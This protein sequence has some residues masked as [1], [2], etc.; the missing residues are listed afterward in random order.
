MQ[1]HRALPLSGVLVVAAGLAQ[2]QEQQAEQQGEQIEEIVVTGSYIPRVSQFDAPAPLTTIGRED[3]AAL[4]VNEISEV[5]DDLTINTGSQNNPDAFTQN[6]ST[7]T[8]N[9]NL[10]GLGVSSTLVM[11]NGRR[12]VQSA[13]ATDRGENFVDTSSL[14]PMIVFDRIEILKDGATSLYGSEAV[15][16]VVN[17]LTRMDF[18]GI[19]LEVGLQTVDGHPQEDT[20]VSVLWGGGSENT[21]VLAAVSMLDR[22]PLTTNDRRLSQPADDTSQ[23]GNPGSFLVP[24]LPANPAYALVWTAAFDTN[25]NGVADALEPRLGLPPVPGARLPV[26]ADPD[27]VTIAAQDPNVVPAIAA[28]VPTPIGPIPLGLCQ[29]DFGRFYSLVPEE[30]RASAYLEVSHDFSE[31]FRGRLELHTADNEATRNNSPSFPFAQF[32][33]VPASHPDNPYGTNVS[34]IGRVAGAGGM[35]SPSIH[36]SDTTRIAASLAGD[37][38]GRWGWDIGVTNSTNDF[39]VF[40]KDVLIDRFG[41]A[42]QGLGG[43]ACDPTTGTPGAG[44]CA[45]FNP[46]GSSL[47]GTGTQNSAALFEDI[48]GDFSYDAESELTTLDG[49]VTGLLGEIGGGPIGIAAGAQLRQEDIAYDY[50]PNSNS[51][52]FFF[53]A[54]NPDFTGD[55]DV[56]AVFGEVVL[57]VTDELEVQL[58]ARYEDYGGGVDSADPKIN[59]LW[60]PTLDLSVRASAGTSFRAPSL[61][62]QFGVQTTLAELIDP[63]VG[64]P[65]FFPVRAQPNPNGAPLNPEEADVLTLGVSYALTENIELGADY[66][67]FDYSE[68]IIQ[69]DPQAILN[70]A[71]LG[72]PQAQTQ[73][74]RD[75]ASGLLLRVDSYYTN[76]STLDTDG[77]DLS[78]TYSPELDRGGSL[79]LGADM[80]L[81]KSYDIVDPQAGSVDGLG[82][83]N[84]ANFATSTPELRANLFANWAFGNHGINVYVRHIDSY[85]DDQVDLGQG[86]SS[87][88]PIDSHVTLDA[89]YN[90]AFRDGAG[91]TLT[92]GATNLLDE[93]P[94]YLATNGGYDSKV[95]DPRGRV[96]YAKASFT[97]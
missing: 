45:Y 35:A 33:T 37:I 1:N 60:R 17:F 92:F 83:R 67:S 90:I 66:W 96:L 55:R 5:I 74:I 52:N 26:F 29:F 64:I 58:A 13:V 19:D 38:G 14:P 23:A 86:P 82:R 85:L 7:G 75:P 51:G 80:T 2:A 20:Q 31:R 43:P 76:A 42:I 32:P 18:R 53:F 93:D 62:Q 72:D 88:R 89:Q 84:F 78:I 27:C 34:F 94:P 50:D 81:I 22:K 87:Y 77:F 95:H 4:G 12:Q 28:S 47:T 97:F 73:V 91:P 39:A 41:L 8:S 71:A 46:W 48:F 10:R 69:Q 59:L 57:P 79:R 11:L 49:F 61:S 36:E 6:F 16:G 30:E 70:A 9:V 3:L 24:T 68:V 25:L 54:A 63:A 65:Q 40:A 15:A 21:H 56:H 44:N